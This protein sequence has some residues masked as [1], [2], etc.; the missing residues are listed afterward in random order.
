ME[1]T[2]GRSGGSEGEE[3][4]RKPSNSRAIGISDVHAIAT[5]SSV[6]LELILMVLESREIE[7]EGSKDEGFEVG[8][9]SEGG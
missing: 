6:C 4:V 7:R 9:K 2:K 3:S 8:K 5:E 1:G